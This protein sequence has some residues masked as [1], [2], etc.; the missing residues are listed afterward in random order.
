VIWAAL[1]YNATNQHAA[2]VVATPA[3]AAQAGPASGAAQPATAPA[4]VT[5]RTS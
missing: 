4:P 5:T 1:F 3:S 2:A